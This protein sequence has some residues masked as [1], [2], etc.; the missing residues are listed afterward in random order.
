MANISILFCFPGYGTGYGTTVV[1]GYSI[2]KQLFKCFISQSKVWR[3]IRQKWKRFMV[4]RH[5]LER[6][7]SSRTTMAYN[8]SNAEVRNVHLPIDKKLLPSNHN[9][10]STRARENNFF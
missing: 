9:P 6:R 2:H 1:Y 3:V 4:N 5:L 10:F 8:L 7:R